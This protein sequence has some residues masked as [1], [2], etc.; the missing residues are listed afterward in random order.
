MRKGAWIAGGLTAILLGV[1]MG[2]AVLA[3]LLPLRGDLPLIDRVPDPLAGE[4]P[5]ARMDAPN[6]VLVI[7]CT[8][9]RDQTSLYGEVDGT[10]PFLESLAAAGVAFDDAIAAAPWTKAASSAILTGHHPV[11]IGMVEP[12]RKRNDRIL[13]PHV[14]TLATHFRGAGYRTVGATANPNLNAIFGF[15]R[16]FDEYLQLR[17]LWRENMSKLDGRDVVDLLDA[18]LDQ[19][20]PA[21]PVFVQVMLVD[22]HAPFEPDP[23][24]VAQFDVPGV[25][26]KV[27]EYRA[28]LR[29]LDEVVSKL[30]ARL[31]AKGFDA[32]NTLFV[33]VS[34][35]GEGLNH[36]A[37]HGKAHGRFLFPS[38]VGAVWT[39]AGPS[40]PAGHRIDGVASQID[41]A[42]TL[43][44]LA[45]VDS[46]RGPGLDLSSAIR[47]QS[48]ITGRE[49]AYTD[50]W[51][52]TVN[53]AAV[54]T[55]KRA[56]QRD[57]D[58]ARGMDVRG[59]FR[60]GCFDRETD[61]HHQ[62]PF[63]ES[64][65][66]DDL[67]AWRTEREVEYQAFD[68]QNAE[69]DE[70]VVDQLKALGYME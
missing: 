41:I 10:T 13:G 26:K 25:P 20:D 29:T 51:F 38:S 32:S 23:A 14:D 63:P 6:V 21:R 66:E 70:G 27:R 17:E 59:R 46:Y 61:P 37:A 7:G 35:H 43:L 53:R 36:P 68:V 47:E 54:Y 58:E 34:D 15:N 22:A 30:H 28:A 67:V 16:G 31:A 69:P 24:F 55:S 56:C 62:T 11:S 19:R 39:L 64:A 40:I 45:G 52:A 49:M 12:G 65:I 8:V 44:G 42:P 33:V 48:P 1:A 3:M 5:E 50:T 18:A 57:F 9:R 2:V 60:E 4:R